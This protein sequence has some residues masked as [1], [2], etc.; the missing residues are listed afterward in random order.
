MSFRKKI[1]VR[2]LAF[3][4]CLSLIPALLIFAAASARAASAWN[5]G[6]VEVPG[7]AFDIALGQSLQKSIP[8]AGPDGSLTVAS[9]YY[10]GV[11]YEVRVSERPPGSEIFGPSETVHTI[12]ALSA[13]RFSG[14]ITPDGTITLGWISGASQF[15]ER[16]VEAITRPA[17]EAGFE[18]PE[19]IYSSPLP[20]RTLA[21]LDLVAGP[22]GSMTAIWSLLD[23]QLGEYLFEVATRISDGTPF[24][25]SE[26]LGRGAYEFPDLAVGPGGMAIAV[27]TDEEDGQIKAVSRPSASADFGA[28]VPLTSGGVDWEYFEYPR[29]A[30]ASDGTTAVSW[31]EGL[32]DESE[33]RAYG[34]RIRPGGSPEFLP[35]VRVNPEAEDAVE[36]GGIAFDG[37]GRLTVLWT[38][39]DRL[40]EDRWSLFSA[41]KAGDASFGEPEL[42]SSPDPL[43]LGVAYRASLAVSPS[44]QAVAVWEQ[45]SFAPNSDDDEVALA[46]VLRNA[47]NGAFLLPAESLWGPLPSS[48]NQLWGWTERV[49]PVILP[50]GSA[51]AVY[52][53]LSDDEGATYVRSTPNPPTPNPQQPRFTALRLSAGP[54]KV[55]RG[56]KVK[57]TVS[58]TNSGN[59]T[60]T[61][62]VRLLASPGKAARVASR[63]TLRV[64]PGK[65]VRRTVKA[66][67]TRKAG[68]KITFKAKSG[69]LARQVQVKVKR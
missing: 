2:G 49:P 69:N 4:A 36:N 18:A 58:I 55:R 45:R 17:D 48:G 34:V 42:L 56:A 38:G 60:G 68:K 54:S 47:G 39:E 31:L 53:V 51:A 22:D 13:R 62:T 26:D 6:S 66:T 10:T 63:L 3:V 33:T 57:L 12:D 52:T 59:G 65:T 7:T 16:S 32:E 8:L 35:E 23:G 37:S 61:A 64:A 11:G 19:V 29:A 28:A 44:G 24:E 46:G 41:V 25:T 15:N 43:D 50:S 1:D 27:W 14:A 40:I 21:G 20:A 9:L 5:P 30:I 67:I